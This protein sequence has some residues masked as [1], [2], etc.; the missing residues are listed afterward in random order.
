LIGSQEC[1]LQGWQTVDGF[2][3]CRPLGGRRAI[4]V[5]DLAILLEEG[6]VHR[7]GLNAQNYVE[8]VIQLDGD[9]THLV[10][11]ARTQPAYVE[12]IAHFSLVVAMQFAAQ[13][14]G[15]VGW[16]DSLNQGFQEIRIE[17]LESLLVLEDQI[18]GIF[19]LHDA[20][21][22]RQ[23]QVSDDRTVL[24]GE[25]IQFS[26]QHG[27]V[28]LGSQLV[29]QVKVSELEEC[30]VDLLKVNAVESRKVIPVMY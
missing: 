4:S 1:F 17:R 11:D 25:L 8:L 6:N 15:N 28:Q 24:L 26:V 10:F 22:V 2:L 12:A 30:I 7:G 16:F 21:T 13:K 3:H 9:G 19:G 27:H 18:C 14:R 5:L 23:L 29:G 20:L